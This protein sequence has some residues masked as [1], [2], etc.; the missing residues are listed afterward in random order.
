MIPDETIM[1]KI[2]LVRGQ[3]VMMDRDLAELLRSRNKNFKATG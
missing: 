2:Y 3:K 1:N